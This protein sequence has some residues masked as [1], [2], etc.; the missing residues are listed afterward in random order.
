[1]MEIFVFFFFLW[2]CLVQ[3]ISS[4]ASNSRRSIHKNVIWSSLTILNYQHRTST[5]HSLFVSVLIQNESKQQ[6]QEHKQSSVDSYVHMYPYA[7]LNVLF[8]F[9]QFISNAVLMLKLCLTCIYYVAIAQCQPLISSPPPK[10]TSTKKDIKYQ[11]SSWYV[12]G[13]GDTN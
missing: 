13:D 4:T 1:M 12:C 2:Q 3:F 10:K 7:I 5:A 9:S 6:Q 11:T 8:T